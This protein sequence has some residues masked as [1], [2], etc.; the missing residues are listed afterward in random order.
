MVWR[1]GSETWVS[2]KD[3]KESNPVEVAKYA[4]A[5]GIDDEAVFAWWV[6][7][8][9]RKRDIIISSVKHRL[10]KKTQNFGIEIP[11]R[12]NQAYEIDKANQNTFW[13]DA[14]Q[15]KMK[16]N[17]VAF[18][19][20][21]HDKNVPVGW[22]KAPGHTIFDV[23]IDFTRKACWVLDVHKTANPEGSTYTGVVSR[24]SVRITLIYSALSGIDVFCAD[25]KN[26]YLQ[27]PASQK[28]Y[29]ICGPK[30]G[31]ENIGKKALIQRA[32]YRG[33]AA[34]R[35]FSNHLRACMQYLDFVSCLADPDVWMRPAKKADG[36]EYYE[37]VLLYIDDAL[38]MSENGEKILQDKIGKYFKLK[39]ESIEPPKIYLGGKLSKVVL[40]NRALA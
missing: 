34:G 6:P 4:S 31:L 33:K 36:S 8:M 24:E 2:L 23:K 30:F 32:L 16:N 26:V 17:G 18:D 3:I 10:R 11:T 35:D 22:K 7:Y 19:V 5:S 25:I 20:L 39:E 40:D 37:F 29:I 27:A 15:K 9:L 1:D 12:L 21:D 13:K 38:V 28:D 14:I